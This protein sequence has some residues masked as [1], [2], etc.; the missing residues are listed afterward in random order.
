MGRRWLRGLRRT[1]EWK[2]F[3]KEL[4]DDRRQRAVNGASR[5][6]DRLHIMLPDPDSAEMI[7]LTQARYP[8]TCTEM[9][10]GDSGCGHQLPPT[11]GDETRAA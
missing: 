6:V 9:P 10:L 8:D 5:I 7:R 3:L 2:A 1:W 4:E 11:G